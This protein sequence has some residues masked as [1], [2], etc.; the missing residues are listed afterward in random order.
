MPSEVWPPLATREGVESDHRCVIFS[1]SVK[2]E[3]DFTWLT[4]TTRKQ[5]DKAVETFARRLAATNWDSLMPD[6]SLPDDLVESFEG[7]T[8]KLVDE[9]FPIKTTRIRSNEPPWVTDGIRRV[10]RLKKRVY[11]SEGKS[12]LWHTLQA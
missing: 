3:K 10:S 6:N 2:R 4:K 12:R 7:Y 11:K 9:L 1:G 8:G 5:T